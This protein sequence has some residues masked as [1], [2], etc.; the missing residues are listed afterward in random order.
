MHERTS[1]HCAVG[2]WRDVAHALCHLCVLFCAFN[3]RQR[4]DGLNNGSNSELIDEFGSFP[5][6]DAELSWCSVTPW[7]GTVIIFISQPY[8]HGT[9]HYNDQ[10]GCFAFTDWAVPC[11]YGWEVRM[12][13]MVV[14]PKHNT[15]LVLISSYSGSGPKHF[16]PAGRSKLT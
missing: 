8:L 5:I 14:P 16:I 4:M 11:K 1:H 9:A 2:C 7:G 6:D 12:T 15:S 13:T 3:K 10:Q